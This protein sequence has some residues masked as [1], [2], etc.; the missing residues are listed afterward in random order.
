M[1]V[2]MEF[3]E[4]QIGSTT[5]KT[6]IME[7]VSQHT[8]PKEQCENRQTLKVFRRIPRFLKYSFRNV[9]KN[10]PGRECSKAI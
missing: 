5:P 3:F 6:A 8:I 1:Y 10:F 7:S 2:L 4:L 9:S